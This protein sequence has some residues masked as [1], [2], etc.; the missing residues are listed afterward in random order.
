MSKRTTLIAAL[1]LAGCSKGHGSIAPDISAPLGEPVP[2]A[3]AEQLEAF[4]RGLEV[5]QHRFSVAEGLGP[6]FNVTFCGACH[7]KPV[8][9]GG[10]G[11]YRNFFIGG[12][13]TSQGA[14][15][16]TES[17]GYLAGG[18]VRLYYYGDEFDA[19]PEVPAKMNVVAQRN[20]IPIFG[21]GL[22][23][24][25]P[26]EVVLANAD[27]EDRN[28]DGIS[29]RHNENQGFVGRFGVKAQTGSIEGFIRGPLMNH[30]GITTNPLTDEQRSQLPV[31]S[32]QA[33]AASSQT[34]QNSRVGRAPVENPNYSNQADAPAGPLTDADEAPD[35][36]MSPQQLFDIVSFTM[37]LAAPEFEPLTERSERGR[38]FFDEVGCAK[39][40]VPRLEGPRGNVPLYSDLLLHDMGEDLGDDIVQGLATGTEFRTQPLWGVAA[41]GPYLHDGR[42]VSLDEAI[43]MHGG[44]ATRVVTAYEELESS[45]R[46]DL[47]EFLLTLGGRD[48]YTPGLV[49]LDDPVPPVGAW[50]G[51]VEAL[52]ANG[53]SLFLA[54]RTLFD[55]E[56]GLSDGV[57]G[58]RFNGDSCRA[59]HFEPLVGGAGP[60]GVNVVRHGV[61][62]EQGE[63]VSP[64]LGTIL[65]R[66]TSLRS[67]ANRPQADSSVFELRNTPHLFGLGLID[68][69]PEATILAGADP[70]DADADGIS[71]KP[72]WLDGTRFGRFGWKGSVPSIEE[73][74]RDAVTMELGMT[75]PIVEGLTFGRIHDNDN[76][77]DPEFSLDDAELL[78]QWL[79]MLAGPPRAEVISPEALDGELLFE[80]TGCADCHTP[81]L[82]GPTGPVP[83]Y[84]DLLLHEILPEGASGIEEA[85][86]TARE[87]RTPPLWGLR[88]TGPYLHN[89]IADT[90]VQAIEAHAG[91]GTASRDAFTGLSEADQ[92]ALI[93]FLE[94]L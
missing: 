11:L 27:P 70:D 74:V 58:P 56:F 92:A 31:D 53:E 86:A 85:G 76:V 19:R 62:N 22:I 61:S 66:S 39:C 47:V 7:E 87:F 13:L 36:E 60:R 17:A 50:G 23:A 81:A 2:Y 72:S 90:L 46:D 59:C 43:R 93:A 42:A 10:A 38:D 25:I 9:G 3:T 71:G 21:T 15:L 24:E 80:S 18:V 51:P 69:I 14:F 49:P 63:F 57:G 78:G 91:E 83:L 73:F 40:H 16:P 67:T 94:T 77:P 4:E 30:A 35:P 33:A 34:G 68:A 5:M 64:S 75:L 45:G 28:G 88:S 20:P 65:H 1:A 84:S 6:A 26:S 79:R 32:S 55:F 48:Q 89:G 41:T 44:E 52:D 29:G 82:E 8:F 12:E 37:L 54:G